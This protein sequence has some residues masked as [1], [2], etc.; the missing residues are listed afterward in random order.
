MEFV[1][2]NFSTDSS[3]PA[4]GEL[5]IAPSP[6][7]G[8]GAGKALLVLEL[9]NSAFPRGAGPVT[10]IILPVDPTLDDMLAATF[11]VR[12]LAGQQL[13]EGC[14][15]FARYARQCLHGQT[16]GQ[17][18]FEDSLA[19]IYLAMRL[20][21]GD[22][23]MEPATARRFSSLWTRLAD[24]ILQAAHAELDPFTAPLPA[25]D[26]DLARLRTLLLRD[27][28]LYRRD[29]ER[30]QRWL[31]RSAAERSSAAGLLLRQPKSQL[32][33]FWC[34]A[35]KNT[36]T[37]KPNMLL[38]AQ[39]NEGQWICCRAPE[40]QL[41]LQPLAE[42]LR[43]A[44]TAAGGSRDNWVT[45]A[46]ATLLASSEKGSCL[47]E[48]R[49]LDM[50]KRW[51][52][53]EV[54]HPPRFKVNRRLLVGGLAVAAIFAVLI[55]VLPGQSPDPQPG[56]QPKQPAPPITDRGF[57]LD[58][59]Q[60]QPTPPAPA[61][62]GKL[63]HV[64]IGVSKYRNPKF[65]LSYAHADAEALVQAFQ[66]QGTIFEKQYS[67]LLTDEQATREG[68]LESLPPLKSKVTQYDLVLVT[69]S[70][71]GANLEDGNSFYFL[72][73]DFDEAKKATTGVY[74]DDFKRYLGNLP[75][76][77]FLVVDTCH[78]G[79]IT[80]GLRGASD[81]REELNRQIQSMLPKKDSGMIV[82]AA[83][84]SSGKALENAE[85][86]HG[87]LTLAL[88]EAISGKHLYQKKTQ[89]S[90]PAPNADGEININD[91][92]Y[93][94]SRRVQELAGGAQAVVTNHTG[95]IALNRIPIAQVAVKNA[96]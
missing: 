45:D 95:N 96:S 48:E 69:L 4:P 54:Y 36:A 14:T 26:A 40:C 2:R 46:D 70:G 52:N 67:R 53:A 57:Q 86:G 76:R 12:R 20:A 78:S 91:L 58:P 3:P 38:T 16:P 79:T 60:L 85:W 17:L 82:M 80:L 34:F 28:R 94:V 61:P 8:R 44:E 6:E 59:G 64:A 9:G 29:V 72:P 35:D 56:P 30:G 84:L 74:W 11:A 63:Y 10:K 7:E 73:H 18:S 37:G 62:R 23:L 39:G 1:F 81:T 21:T 25:L 42:Q 41:S 77:V 55:L 50:V 24:T 89:T 15:A 49:I 66:Q 93:Y 33:K 5:Y 87:V 51:A 27:Q 19:G 13:P 32:F 22:S 68:I 90:L 83:C 31:L 71:H 47:P 65:N 92:S 88:L 43:H 75:C